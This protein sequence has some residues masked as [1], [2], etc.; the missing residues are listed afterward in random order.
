MVKVAKRARDV[1]VTLPA[2]VHV[3]LID[4]RT[5]ENRITRPNA[6]PKDEPCHVILACYPG[7]WWLSVIVYWRVLVWHMWPNCSH[8]CAHSVRG[9]FPLAITTCCR[10]SSGHCPSDFII[11]VITLYYLM[12]RSSTMSTVEV[13]STLVSSVFNF[14]IKLT[15]LLLSWRQRVI[16]K[17]STTLLDQE[18]VENVKFVFRNY[19]KYLTFYAWNE[20]DVLHLFDFCWWAD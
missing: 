18:S 1:H 13:L 17:M 11:I 2:A 16:Y 7:P 9:W 4:V 19:F 15:Y 5:R 6:C 10:V 3:G 20:A 14:W 8:T 12:G